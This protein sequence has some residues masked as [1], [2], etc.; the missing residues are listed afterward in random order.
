MGKN[1]LSWMA[2]G[3]GA[4][5]ASAL[6]YFASGQAVSLKAVAVF[7]GTGLLVRAANWV[8]STFGPKPE[9]LQAQQSRRF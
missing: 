9:A 2:A 4:L 3:I 5:L 8:V 1:F 6:Q 7:I